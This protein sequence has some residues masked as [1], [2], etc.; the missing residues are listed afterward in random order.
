[1]D[2]ASQR[3]TLSC[4]TILITHPGCSSASTSEQTRAGQ[5]QARHENVKHSTEHLLPLLAHLEDGRSLRQL[6]TQAPG[7]ATTRIPLL[8]LFYFLGRNTASKTIA[9]AT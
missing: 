4:R 9:A 8:G 3:T 1:M 6:L 2:S 5:Q 7:T